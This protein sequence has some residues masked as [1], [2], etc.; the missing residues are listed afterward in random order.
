MNENPYEPPKSLISSISGG[1]FSH[2][3]TLFI[4]VVVSV[5]TLMCSWYLVPLANDL[6]T[7]VILQLV[8]F[9]YWSLRYTIDVFN[10]YLAFLMG[11][12]IAIKLVKH[13]RLY[14]PVF[15]GVV[16]FIAFFIELGGFDCM[17]VCGLPLWYDVASLFKHVMGG[18]TAWFIYSTC[19][20]MAKG[21][22]KTLINQSQ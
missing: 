19:F 12:L 5:A 13:C 17:G 11:G 21:S 16:G 20:S 4:L 9:D 18:V 7:R 15:V 1:E 22:S 14:I 8:S 10:T 2:A 3:K 6:F